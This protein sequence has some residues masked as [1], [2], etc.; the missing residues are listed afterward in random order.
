MSASRVG[1]YF[2]RADA[3]FAQEAL[4]GAGIISV[5]ETDEGDGPSPSPLGEPDALVDAATLNG[6]H[7]AP[8]GHPERDGDIGGTAI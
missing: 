1:D 5:L 3:G 8:D 2:S 4:T 6:T 7:R